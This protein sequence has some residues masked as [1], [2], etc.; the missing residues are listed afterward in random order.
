MRQHCKKSLLLVSGIFM[1]LIGGTLTLLACTLSVNPVLAQAPASTPVPG[2]DAWTQ[3]V[4]LLFRATNPVAAV[5]PDGFTSYCA[6][7]KAWGIVVGAENRGWTA[8]NFIKVSGQGSEVDCAFDSSG[9]LHLVWSEGPGVQYAKL[10][11]DGTVYRVRL[12]PAEV[13]A[14]GRT[15]RPSIATSS[16]RKSVV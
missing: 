2:K 6:T 8:G 5:S 3:P 4:F 13:G 7:S 15:V 14:T 12:L 1:V 9:T 10:Y 11:R 16:D